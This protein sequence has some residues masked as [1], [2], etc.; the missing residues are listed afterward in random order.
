LSYHGGTLTELPNIPETMT[1]HAAPKALPLPVRLMNLAAGTRIKEHTEHYLAAENGFARLH[2][3]IVTNDRVV[4][5]L[6]GTQV[7]LNEGECWYLRLSDPHSVENNG[8]SDR[9]HLV[10]D[11]DINAWL[12]SMLHAY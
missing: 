1:T 7:V 4:F 9:V 11:A 10:I 6:N 2:I 8:Q 5:R 3:P 12:E